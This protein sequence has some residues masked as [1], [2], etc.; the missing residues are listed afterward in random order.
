M[1]LK[2]LVKLRLLVLIERHIALGVVKHGLVVG[3][4]HIAAVVIVSHAKS[5]H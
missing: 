5:T 1:V 2:V 4:F 3:I